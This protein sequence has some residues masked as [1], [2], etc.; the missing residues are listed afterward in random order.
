M[1][2]PT[3]FYSKRQETQ[4]AKAVNGKRTANSGATPFSK[5]DVKTAD[6][7][8]E[9]KTKTCPSNSMTIQLDWIKKNEE[10][11]FAMNKQYSA[12]AIDFGRET[13]YYIINE[14]MFKK[15]LNFIKE[16]ESND[17]ERSGESNL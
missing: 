8:I 1:N 5:G 11:A 7:L 17:K 13:N 10:E 12:V 16:E 3:R 9:A 14:R 2:R 15:L 4:I 6:C